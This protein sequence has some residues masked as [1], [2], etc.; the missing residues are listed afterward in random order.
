[1]AT[2]LANALLGDASLADMEF[3]AAFSAV[4]LEIGSDVAKLQ[5]HSVLHCRCRRL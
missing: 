2:V 1:M 3:D 5:S 4:G